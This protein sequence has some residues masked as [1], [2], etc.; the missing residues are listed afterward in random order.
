MAAVFLPSL[1]FLFALAFPLGW[2]DEAGPRAPARRP[3]QPAD[4]PLPPGHVRALAGAQR[5][6]LPVHAVR[7]SPGQDEAD[8]RGALLRRRRHRVGRRACDP[9]VGRLKPRHV[10][11][12]ELLLRGL[13]LERDA[14]LRPV[15]DFAALREVNVLRHDLGHPQ[16]A[17]RA[18]RRLD[19]SG[20]RVLPGLRARSDQVC[21]SVNA[22]AI[23]LDA[24]W[25]SP[26]VSPTGPRLPRTRCG[27][28]LAR[29][30]L[31][32]AHD[33]RQRRRERDRAEQGSAATRGRAHRSRRGLVRGRLPSAATRADAVDHPSPPRLHPRRPPHRAGAGRRNR[34][35]HRSRTHHRRQA[36]GVHPSLRCSRCLHADHRG[37]RPCRGRRNRV[38][39]SRPLLPQGRPGDPTRRRHLRRSCR[40]AVLGGGHRHR[41]SRRSRS[42]MP[43]SRCGRPT[44]TAS[45]TSSTPTSGWRDVARLRA[46]ADGGYRF[47]CSRPTPYPIPDDGPV[48]ALL[49]AVGRSPMRAAHLHFLV[50][51]PGYRTLV[52]HVF[53][54]GDPQLEIG[55]SVFGVK[56]S[57]IKRFD[58]Q[59][60]GTPTPDGRDLGDRSWARAT[61]DIVLTPERPSCHT[62][63]KK[64]HRQVSVRLSIKRECWRL[65]PPRPLADGLGDGRGVDAGCHAAGNRHCDCRVPRRGVV[66][67]DAGRGDDWVDGGHVPRVVRG[68][69]R[70]AHLRDRARGVADGAR[71]YGRSCG[72][73]KAVE[74]PVATQPEPAA[75][76]RASLTCTSPNA[77]LTVP[78][79]T[80]LAL[81][82]RFPASAG[83]VID[84]PPPVRVI[85]APVVS[86]EAGSVAAGMSRTAEMGRSSSGAS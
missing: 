57:L 49:K 67:G 34:V 5:T 48:G 84:R 68:V 31:R 29:Q 11:R 72:G 69:G 4:L 17:D 58:E 86:A 76:L 45:T 55:D 7:R 9:V 75:A 12:L 25:V 79:R 30:H 83:A 52:T 35:P 39:R 41:H 14:K 20:R 21:N 62:T 32:S 51:S 82:P 47:W 81:V 38:H 16:I 80:V 77:P 37:Q 19:R 64:P 22:H 56:D 46:D 2:V 27:Y 36:T 3:R 74:M 85:V 61:F 65:T 6:P 28:H 70:G 1:V 60:A 53:V 66:A 18:A 78:P 63:T 10:R 40:T 73:V 33:G 15:H 24:G 42:A 8:H 71:G 50:E 59:P 44:R 26:S 43:G 54:E 13:V 23:L